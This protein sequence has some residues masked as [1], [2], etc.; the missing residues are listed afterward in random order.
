VNLVGSVAQRT[1]STCQSQLAH[2]DTD[3]IP[4]PSKAAR[5]SNARLPAEIFDQSLD[6]AGNF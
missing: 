6:G 1:R 2:F 3:Q 5:R 4:I